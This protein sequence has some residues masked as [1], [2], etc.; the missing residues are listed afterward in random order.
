MIHLQLCMSW[1]RQM[2]VLLSLGRLGIQ[3]NCVLDML[4]Y[5]AA[6]EGARVLKG[7]HKPEIQGSGLDEG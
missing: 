1:F 4:H 3:F 7:I 2:V 6:D 5:A